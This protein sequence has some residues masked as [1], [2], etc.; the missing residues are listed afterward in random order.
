M[1]P[2]LGGAVSIHTVFCSQVAKSMLSTSKIVIMEIPTVPRSALNY[3]KHESTFV[4]AGR[5]RFF[6]DLLEKIKTALI[7]IL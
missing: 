1:C 2:P 5:P 4:W 3:G 7:N 6:S